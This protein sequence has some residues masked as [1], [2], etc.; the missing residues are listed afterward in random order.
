VK[1]A[2]CMTPL[3][4]VVHDQTPKV[5]LTQ[6]TI[7]VTGLWACLLLGFQRNSVGVINGERG[8]VEEGADVGREVWVQGCGE[9]WSVGRN[10]EE[11]SL[12]ELFQVSNEEGCT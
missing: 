3:R 2:G 9:G 5:R 8:S 11:V 7:A 12:T 4:P 6:L 1:N 10:G